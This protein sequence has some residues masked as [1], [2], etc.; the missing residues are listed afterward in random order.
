MIEHWERQIGEDPLTNTFEPVSDRRY[1]FSTQRFPFNGDIQLLRAVV[2]DEPATYYGGTVN[3]Y[4]EI[5]LLDTDDDFYRQFSNSYYQWTSGFTF[6]FNPTTNEWQSDQVYLP[7]DPAIYQEP[8]DFV[9]WF[10]GVGIAIYTV[11]MIVLV[12]Y[13]VR[14]FRTQAR[15]QTRVIEL[16]EQTAKT[17]DQIRDGN[18]TS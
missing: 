16:S 3:G 1:R 18:R 10:F 5:Q 2:I 6:Y 17:L 9:A 13:T 8:V 11:L 7:R 14:W 15:F 4:I 12:W